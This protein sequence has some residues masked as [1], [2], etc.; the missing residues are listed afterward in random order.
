MHLVQR[1]IQDLFEVEAGCGEKV[2]E[3][4]VLHQEPSPSESIPP[5]VARPYIQALNAIALQT[6]HPEQ[7]PEMKQLEKREERMEPGDEGEVT[8]EASQLEELASVVEQVTRGRLPKDCD[9][10]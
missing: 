4:V 5:H 8:G 1:T 7:G 10:S 3:F 9:A 6:L 2:E